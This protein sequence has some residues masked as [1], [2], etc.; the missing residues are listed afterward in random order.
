M[1]TLI[2]IHL[3][4][5]RVLEILAMYICTII[6]WKT[7]LLVPLHMHDAFMPLAIL[8]ACSCT[9][10]T[11]KDGQMGIPQEGQKWLEMLV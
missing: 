10:T 4:E 3:Y 2:I 1:Q 5:V 7:E 8:E 9:T 11:V 6:Y